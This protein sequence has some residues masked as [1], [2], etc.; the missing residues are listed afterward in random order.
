MVVDGAAFLKRR[1]ARSLRRPGLSPITRQSNGIDQ[2]VK[3]PFHDGHPC[4][5]YVAWSCRHLAETIV[6]QRKQFAT[7]RDIGRRRFDTNPLILL[8]IP[9]G[10][11]PVTYRLG[12]FLQS[13]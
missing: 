7:W 8:V 4:R 10:I 3:N 11:E 9:T 5:V 12:N 13:L 6:N 1:L 2:I